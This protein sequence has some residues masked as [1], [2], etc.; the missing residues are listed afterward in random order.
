MTGR[1]CRED[2]VIV[3]SAGRFHEETEPAI[4]LGNGGFLHGHGVFTTLRLNQ[5]RPLLLDRH[6]ERL[7][8]HAASLGLPP[9]H[10]LPDTPRV[11][12]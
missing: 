12:S 11:I 2:T 1:R 5:G 6:L 3:Y 9:S 10:H 7:G 8:N 4:P